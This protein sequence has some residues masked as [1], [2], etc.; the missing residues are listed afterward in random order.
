MAK[1]GKSQTQRV[2]DMIDQFMIYHNMGYGIPEI[3]QKFEITTTTVYSHLQEI[4]VK[5][6]YYDRK[7]LL[8]RIH[9]KHNISK[10]NHQSPTSDFDEVLDYASKINLRILQLVEEIGSIKEDVLC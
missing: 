5:N 10:Y 3:A 2:T 8:E 4:A 9:P 1:R 7:E 6:G